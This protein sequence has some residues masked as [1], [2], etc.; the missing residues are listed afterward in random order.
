MKNK[1]NIAYKVVNLLIKTV[2]VI[3][4]FGFIY[5]QVF[6]KK[7]IE[8]IQHLFNNMMGRPRDLL[9]LFVVVLL[10]F[11]N[12]GLEAIKWKFLILKIE[13]PS[14]QLQKYSFNAKFELFM[15]S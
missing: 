12:W 1:K 13:K 8:T 11:I 6:Y 5:K 14:P 9:L 7:D 10:M 2:V 4:V 15:L 3:V